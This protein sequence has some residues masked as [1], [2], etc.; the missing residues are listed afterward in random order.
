MAKLGLSHRPTFRK[1]YLHPA[2]GANFI[3]MTIP[4]SPN[5]KN[6]KYILTS[7][8]KRYAS[9]WVFDWKIFL[10]IWNF[11]ECSTSWLTVALTKTCD[12]N[13]HVGAT[14]GMVWEKFWLRKILLDKHVR[15]CYTHKSIENIG[16]N[17]LLSSPARG[18][19]KA[20]EGTRTL[21]IQLG[22]LSTHLLRA[23]KSGVWKSKIPSLRKV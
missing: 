4:E 15:R 6:Q 9:D 8:G 7:R 5:A 1:N 11:W 2:M 12:I 18:D 22:R 10:Y 14:L 3:E 21:N 20:G 16:W 17:E 23:I 13:L 19:S